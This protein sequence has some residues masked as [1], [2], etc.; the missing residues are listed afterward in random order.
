MFAQKRRHRIHNIGLFVVEYFR[1]EELQ[2]DVGQVF[3]VSQSAVASWE[4]GPERK[5]KAIPECLRPLVLRWTETGEGLT[6]DELKALAAR[7]S[8]VKKTG[9]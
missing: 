8:G 6:E 4:R 5:G 2:S 7:R 3:K 1:G 9:P